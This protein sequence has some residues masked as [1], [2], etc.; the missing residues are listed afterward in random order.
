MVLLESVPKYIKF[1]GPL[2]PLTLNTARLLS[3]I[4]VLAGLFDRG[5]G[6]TITSTAKG[7]GTAL[8]AMMKHESQ[9]VW[10]RWLYV[11]ASKYMWSNTLVL[12]DPR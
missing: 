10:F 4:P 2:Y 5:K 9:L 1:T 12:A 11:G 3:E 7:Y 6:L 8:E